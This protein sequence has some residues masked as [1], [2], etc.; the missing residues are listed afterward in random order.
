MHKFFT[1]VTTTLF[2]IIGLFFAID[3]SA[4]WDHT[5]SCTYDQGTGECFVNL[6]EQEPFGCGPGF[7]PIPSVCTSI[8]DDPSCDSGRHDCRE[9]NPSSRY[10]CSQS[11]CVPS[12][13]GEFA[14]ADACDAGCTGPQTARYKC[15]AP[16]SGNCTQ[17]NPATDPTCTLTSTQCV[18]ACNPTPPPASNGTTILPTCNDGKGINTAIGCIPFGTTNDLTA[19]FL[20]WGVG[21]GGGVA[22]ILMLVAG[23]QIMTSSGDPKRLLAGKELLTAAISG[24]IL[25]IFSVV[26]V[27][28]LGVDILGVI[29]R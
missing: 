25:L 24:V 15:T 20:R 5:F 12:P 9:I 3:A 23:F 11:Q 21:I 17:C 4:A 16:Y 13:A 6:G 14:T 29:P 2:L 8:G 26:I 10:T 18:D 28:I 22:L 27:R 7:E 19:F 1:A